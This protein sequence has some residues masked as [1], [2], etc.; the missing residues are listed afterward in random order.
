MSGRK[1]REQWKKREGKGKR[2]E[3]KTGKRKA[4]EREIN[5]YQDWN[6]TQVGALS[7]SCSLD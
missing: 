6:K 4:S 5:K 7:M 1:E 3:I 2:R